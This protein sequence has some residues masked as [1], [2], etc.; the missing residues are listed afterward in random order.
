MWSKSVHTD[1]ERIFVPSIEEAREFPWYNKPWS[2]KFYA[3]WLAKHGG[4]S[5]E[6][7]A[8]IDPDE[9]FLKPLHNEGTKRSGL[10]CNMPEKYVATS[11]LPAP[12]L[13]RTFTPTL[14]VPSHLLSSYPH[15]YSN[16]YHPS[17]QVHQRAARQA[18]SPCWR[19][20]GHRA[21]GKG[22][23]ADIR[24]GAWNRDQI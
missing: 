24:T 15:A 4:V 12:T 21:A 6:V 14:I 5:N 11:S 19:G 8:I 9:F 23:S 7:F 18:A 3:D 1:V 22:S 13:T 16:P 20:T 10:I 2:Y 17:V